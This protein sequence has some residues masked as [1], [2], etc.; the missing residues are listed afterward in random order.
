MTFNGKRQ[1]VSFFVFFSKSFIKFF[2]NHALFDLKNR[3]QWKYVKNGSNNYIQKL[4]NKNL[5]NFKTNFKIKKILRKN[6]KI[7]IISDEEKIYNFDKFRVKFIISK[8]LNKYR[9]VIEA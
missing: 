3:P 6:N 2:S 9:G 7:Q 5:F 8:T 4:I 1:N